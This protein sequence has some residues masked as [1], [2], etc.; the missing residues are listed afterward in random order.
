MTTRYHLLGWG[1]AISV[2]AAVIGALP[3]MERFR[4]LHILAVGTAAVCVTLLAVRRAQ[5]PPDPDLA[6]LAD[7]R[8]EALV[9]AAERLGALEAMRAI[10]ERR[11]RPPGSSGPGSEPEGSAD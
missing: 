6:S 2:P 5:R 9:R 4:G 11:K 10:E 3:N 1:A 8:T 7:A